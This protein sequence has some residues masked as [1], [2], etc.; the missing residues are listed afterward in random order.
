MNPV[1]LKYG[2]LKLSSV[3][4][5]GVGQSR[6]HFSYVEPSVQ[7]PFREKVNNN[8]SDKPPTTRWPSWKI[9]ISK[10]DPV[11]SRNQSVFELPPHTHK[12]KGTWSDVDPYEQALGAM[13]GRYPPAEVSINICINGPFAH[14][15]VLSIPQHQISGPARRKVSHDLRSKCLPIPFQECGVKLTYCS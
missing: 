11:R 2:Q 6:V 7:T 12:D 14:L 9:G 10:V 8:F 5:K 4:S 15:F 13:L 1:N 3:M